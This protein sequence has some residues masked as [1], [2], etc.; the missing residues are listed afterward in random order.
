LFSDP[1]VPNWNRREKPAGNG[2]ERR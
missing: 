1:Y 2:A